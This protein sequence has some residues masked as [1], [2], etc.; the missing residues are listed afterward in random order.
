MEQI[1]NRATNKTAR[2]VPEWKTLDEQPRNTPSNGHRATPNGGKETEA[3]TRKRKYERAQR[4]RGG[5]RGTR[6]EGGEEW[7]EKRVR[8]GWKEK[9]V[10]EGWKKGG[11]NREGG[12]DRGKEGGKYGGWE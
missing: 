1:A 8:E 6:R 10:R 5:E 4:E 9:R 3:T 2:N 12:S 7:K 11:W